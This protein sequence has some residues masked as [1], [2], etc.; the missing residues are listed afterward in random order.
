M[1][2]R[3]T[4]YARGCA[5]FPPWHVVCSFTFEREV[6]GALDVYV[7]VRDGS[8]KSDSLSF[9]A[10]V[11]SRSICGFLG[12]TGQLLCCARVEV[13][14]AL[15]PAGWSRGG[16]EG[17]WKYKD[18]GSAPDGGDSGG[19]DEVVG[20]TTSITLSRILTNSLLDQRFDVCICLV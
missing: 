12:L 15:R 7:G 8:Q 18:G 19:D 14:L 1:N 9:G 20:W 5:G 3:R 16:G 13:E 10:S 17:Y 11:C 4:T 6:D 2:R